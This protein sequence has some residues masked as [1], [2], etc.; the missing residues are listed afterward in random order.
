M[1][2]KSEKGKMALGAARAAFGLAARLVMRLPGAG[3]GADAFM[4]AREMAAPHLEKAEIRALSAARLL[5]DLRLAQLE[6][7]REEKP[8]LAEEDRFTTIDIE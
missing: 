3:L 6:L 2:G 1:S 5:I 7:K 8:A 4:A